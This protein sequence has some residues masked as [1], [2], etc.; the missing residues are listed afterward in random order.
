MSL[1][2][3]PNNTSFPCLFHS[4]MYP[5][6]PLHYPR[7]FRSLLSQSKV[8]PGCLYVWRSNGRRLLG[9][10]TSAMGLASGNLTGSGTAGLVAV[11]AMCGCHV[12][13]SLAVY[14]KSYSC[15]SF[16]KAFSEVC[17]RHLMLQAVLSTCAILALGTRLLPRCQGFSGCRPM[18]RS[19]PKVLPQFG[20]LLSF[21]HA[22]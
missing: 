1:P 19:S 6:G 15:H 2:R 5:V 3:I 9:K 7:T 11:T 14:V 20:A 8:S 10:A 16:R 17:L 21:L 22:D 4:P 18:R 12:A 13:P